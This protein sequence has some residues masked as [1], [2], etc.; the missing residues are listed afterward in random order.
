MHLHAVNL[1]ELV[2]NE[3]YVN[4]RSGDNQSFESSAP[5]ASR[6]LGPGNLTFLEVAIIV[7]T[8]WYSV[9]CAVRCLISLI[10]LSL[11]FVF[12]VV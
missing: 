8:W 6:W 9:F 7:V 3:H 12:C 4:W 1:H 10:S 2:C 11:S 5:V